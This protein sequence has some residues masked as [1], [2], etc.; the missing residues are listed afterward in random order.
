MAMRTTTMRN[1]AGSRTRSAAALPVAAAL[2]AVA[3]LSVLAGCDINEPK[4]PTFDTTLSLP[5][6]VERLDV[7]DAID[8]EDFLAVSPDGSLLFHVD[9][10]PDTLSFDF[11][12]SA[13]VSAQSMDHGLGSFELASVGPLTY[14]FLLQDVWAPAA[15]ANG[16]TTIVPAFPLAATSPDQDVPDVTSATLSAGT[17]AVTVDNG[18]PVAISAASGPNQLVLVLEGSDGAEFATF[19]FAVIP[20]GASRTVTVDLAGAVMPDRLRVRLSGGSAGSGGQFVTVSGTDALDVSASFTNLV[21]SSATAV[22]GAQ[23]FNTTFSSPLPSGYEVTEA[24][25]ASGTSQLTVTNSMPV[26]CT[27]TLTW[28]DLRNANGVPLVEQF[29]LA[30]G[31]AAVRS[32]NFTGYTLAAGGSPL[33]ALEASVSVTSPGSSGQPVAMDAGDGLSADLAA[34]SI[35]FASVTGIVPESIVT[36]EPTVQHIDLPDELSGLSLTAARLTLHLDTTASLPGN[37]DLTLRGTD[38]DGEVTDLMI[39]E[40]LNGGPDQALTEIILDQDNSTIVQ[41]LNSMP[42]RVTLLGQ[43]SLGGDGA[44]GTVRPGDTA[45]VRWEIEAPVEVVIDDATLDSDPRELDVDAELQERISTHAQGARAQLEV[46]NHLPVAL[47]LTVLVGQDI[48]TLDT[49]PALTIGPLLVSA[50]VTSPTTHVV[51]QSVISRPAFDLTAE[52][53]RVFGMPGLVTK[54]VAMLPS[55]NGQPVRVLSTDYLE[56]RGLVQLDVLVDDQF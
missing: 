41:F 7:A 44:L 49:A 25:V 11:D 2:A 43:V 12:L 16:I 13:E 4:M 53:A 19:P 36:L 51:T 5:L 37:V 31:T 34:T 39:S 38:A 42:E 26:P 55:T 30:A 27:A 33:T 54:V 32:I 29:T 28:A 6:G 10:D 17:A 21:V 18:L 20:A 14:G 56:V 15:G 3:A 8:S 35:S 46:L 9:G 22:V 40:A 23:S 48:N 47:Q 24:V 52:Q 1:R 50:G 45:V